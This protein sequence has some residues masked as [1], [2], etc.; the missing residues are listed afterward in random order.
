M[1]RKLVSIRRVKA[2]EPIPNADNIEVARVDGWQCVVKKGEFKEGDYGVYFEID[3]F[4]PIEPRYEFLRKGCY[5]K[6]SNGE[7]GF[8]LRT[9]RLRGTLSQGL[10]LPL[11]LFPECD[12]LWEGQ[13]IEKYLDQ[14]LSE[15]FDVK[16]YEPPIPPNLAGVCKGM[17]PSFIQKTDQERIQN[18]PEYFELFKD[19]EFEETEKVDGTS[20]TYY[21]NE[22]EFGVCSRNL[23]LKESEGNTQ[24]RIARELDLEN[25]LK[26]LKRNIALQGEMVGEGI[27]GNPYKLFGQHLFIFDIYDIDKRRY[28]TRKERLPIYLEISDSLLN[29]ENG[30]IK[31][32]LLH[33]VPTIRNNVKV[34][35]EHS[36]IDEL[37][38]RCEGESFLNSITQREGL[39]YKSCEIY[40]PTGNIVSFKVINNWIL[41]EEKQ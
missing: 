13:E 27:Q 32:L 33:H 22:G 6:L 20:T 35:R 19:M 9:I 12:A 15:G 5:K 23:E 21:I 7:E 37:L 28:L 34:F 40:P 30:E 31:S 29:T 39:V 18:L 41:L 16:K 38:L 8:R 14:D 4:L 17:F 24:W 11:R 3:S 25:Q 36:A 1:E 10:I 26:K 2:L